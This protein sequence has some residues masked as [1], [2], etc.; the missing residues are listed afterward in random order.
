MMEWV[1]GFHDCLPFPVGERFTVT[2]HIE[3][4][5]AKLGVRPYRLIIPSM[6]AF[7]YRVH[8][9]RIDDISQLSAPIPAAVFSE[10]GLGTSVDFAVS[11]ETISLIV[12]RVKN[13]KPNWCILAVRRL[14]WISNDQFEAG[15]FYAVM[16]CETSES[17]EPPPKRVSTEKET[18][19]GICP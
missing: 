13:K 12:D 2:A 5:F 18:S 8:D 17:E 19:I 1:I 14:L 6:L 15:T 16:L 3:E 10:T 9:I 11:K 4:R 7:H